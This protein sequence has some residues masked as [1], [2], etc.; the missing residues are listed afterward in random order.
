[1]T[2]HP[3]DRTII[4]G[5]IVRLLSLVV[6]VLGVVSFGHGRPAPQSSGA[7]SAHEAR[8]VRAPRARH[9]AIARA[10]AH[11][12]AETRA[13]ALYDDDDD[14]D[15]DGGWLVPP[16][17]PQ[18]DDDAAPSEIAT[19]GLSEREAPPDAATP[20]TAVDLGPAA[21]HDRQDEPPPRA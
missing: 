9:L 17:T 3:Q 10:L 7:S 8:T 11:A 15:D 16:P 5:L 2:S 13:H 14:D 4:Y 18:N 1:L 19:Y 12:Y 20:A 21:G 6:L